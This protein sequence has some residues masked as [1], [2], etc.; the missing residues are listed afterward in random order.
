[1]TSAQRLCV[2]SVVMAAFSMLLLVFIAG[3]MGIRLGITSIAFEGFM[4][5][6]Q[7]LSA[8]AAL[9]TGIF[10]LRRLS[11]DRSV[12]EQFTALAWAGTLLGSVLSVFV[13]LGL[14]GFAIAFVRGG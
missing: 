9:S 14:V 8:V 4:L 7:Y 12:P 6:V 13:V 3:G 10:S 11:K 2:T 1:M 5:A